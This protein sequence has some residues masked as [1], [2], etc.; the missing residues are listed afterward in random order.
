MVWN[1]ES[2]RW[3][4]RPA[5]DQQESVKPDPGKQNEDECI[6]TSQGSSSTYNEDYPTHSLRN[7]KSSSN[8]DRVT[9]NTVLSC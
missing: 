5:E 3:T 1:D 9:V 6:Q 4:L 2:Y 7:Y 8:S